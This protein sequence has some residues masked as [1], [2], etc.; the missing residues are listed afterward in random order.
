MEEWGLETMSLLTE[1]IIPLLELSKS[2]PLRIN[3]FYIFEQF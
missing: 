2:L 3:S 1:L